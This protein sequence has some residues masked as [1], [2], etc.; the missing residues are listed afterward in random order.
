MKHYLFK[1]NLFAFLFRNYTATKVWFT[2]V[3]KNSVF[4]KN[5]PQKGEGT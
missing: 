4:T 2:V 1:I 3:C 5:P